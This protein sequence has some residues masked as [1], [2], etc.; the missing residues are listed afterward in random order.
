MPCQ[1]DAFLGSAHAHAAPPHVQPRLRRQDSDGTE[2][3][4]VLLFTEYYG[5]LCVLS[6]VCCASKSKSRSGR[7][8]PLAAAYLG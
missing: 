6:V 1:L 2:Y 8:F 4:Y 5:V 7:D 3:S